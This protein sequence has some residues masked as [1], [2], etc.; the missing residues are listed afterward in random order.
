MRNGDL[1]MGMN[2]EFEMVA[3]FHKAFGHPLKETPT[4]MDMDR[5]KKR[6]GWMLEEID[7]FLE[8]V[9]NEDV[10]EQA[11]AMIDV[12]YFALGTLVEMG[13]KPERLFEIVQEANMSKLWEDG[14]PRYRDSDNKVMKPTGW[15]DPHPRLKAEVKR[16]IEGNL[17]F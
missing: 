17:E 9:S 12:M 16:Q 14:K 11:D 13:V 7:E 5:A 6:Y 8:A 15:K 2:K 10:V 3:D 1:E 4:S